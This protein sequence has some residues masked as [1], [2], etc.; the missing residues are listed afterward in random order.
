MRCKFNHSHPPEPLKAATG[1]PTQ[2]WGPRPYHCPEC[3]QVVANPLV[4]GRNWVDYSDAD[5]ARIAGHPRACKICF[6]TRGPE[7]TGPRQ[8]SKAVGAAVTKLPSVTADDLSKW[9]RQ[10]LRLLDKFDHRSTPSAGPVAR[11]TRLKNEGLIPRKTAALM[12]MLTETRNA[13]EYEDERPTHAE[14]E[15]VKNAWTAIV[16][17][18]NARGF[19]LRAQ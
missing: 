4:V 5:K 11:I 9:R 14:S 8:G 7:A 12:I 1:N 6:P 13:A 2:P 19:D 10:L 15:A 16:E 17:W 3:P 18:A